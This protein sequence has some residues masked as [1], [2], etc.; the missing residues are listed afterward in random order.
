MNIRGALTELVKLQEGLAIEE[1]I[2]AQIVKAYPVP[3]PPSH[4]LSFPCF[5]NTARL[6]PTVFA[7]QLMQRTY[8]VQMQ[9]LVKDA[10][11]DRACDIALAFEEELIR[12]LAE[13]DG[14]TLNNAVT[15]IETIEGEL[16]LLEWNGAGYP[17]LDYFITL[18]MAESRVR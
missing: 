5:I 16:G 1:P 15:N 8:V 10:D 14:V 4:A 6:Q 13:D 11:V 12:A 17:G 3:P 9:M 7:S 2:E 18:H